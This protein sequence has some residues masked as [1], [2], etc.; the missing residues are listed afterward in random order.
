MTHRDLPA[1]RNF[2]WRTVC[3]CSA[4]PAADRVGSG[5]RHGAQSPGVDLFTWFSPRSGLC[6]PK[7]AREHFLS[8][9]WSSEPCWPAAVIRPADRAPAGNTLPL[10]DCRERKWPV[11]RDCQ[12]TIVP[13]GDSPQSPSRA[14][15]LQPSVMEVAPGTA[16]CP[17][18]RQRVAGQ[19][20][21]CA[22]LDPHLRQPFAL[23][24]RG[25]MH[26]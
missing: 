15:V 19:L 7:D 4:F 12:E 5:S 20:G 22:C 18:C 10:A 24:E 21:G 1:R 13:V 14:S 26:L 9:N 16:T 3:C 17:R 6:L 25:R 8:E 2:P 23:P 11:S